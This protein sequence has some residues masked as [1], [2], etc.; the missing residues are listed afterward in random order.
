MEIIDKVIEKLRDR[1]DKPSLYKFFDFTMEDLQDDP[2]NVKAIVDYLEMHAGKYEDFDIHTWVNP[3]TF[4]PRVMIILLPTA[5]YRVHM[6]S[7][8]SKRFI[9]LLQSTKE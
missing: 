2:E 1:L 7:N 8:M 4:T 5:E 6:K 3:D 9:E